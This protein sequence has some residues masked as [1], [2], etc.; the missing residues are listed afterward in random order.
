MRLEQ[1]RFISCGM[2]FFIASGAVAWTALC[3]VGNDGATS[4][5][6]AATLPPRIGDKLGQFTF[7]DIRF[8]PRTLNDLASQ[9]EPVQKRAFVLVFT[10]TTCP[11]VQRYFPRL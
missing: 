3:A 1:L 10:N 5:E 11:L 6:T 7:T 9:Q 8:L 2:R 4:I